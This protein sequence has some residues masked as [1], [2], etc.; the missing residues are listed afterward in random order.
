MATKT[1]CD[2]CGR[3]VAI[4]DRKHLRLWSKTTYRVF[5]EDDYDNTSYELCEDCAAT[6]QKCLAGEATEAVK[7]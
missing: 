5:F 6:I 4:F 2:R 3:E 7:E 1:F